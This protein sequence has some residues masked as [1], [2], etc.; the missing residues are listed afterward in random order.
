MKEEDLNK[1]KAHYTGKYP[2]KYKAYNLNTLEN[3]E[4]KIRLAIDGFFTFHESNNGFIV[5]C[6]QIVAYYNCGGIHALKR[7]F[8]C[9]KNEYEIH[10]LDLNTFNNNFNNLIYL[11]KVVHQEITV[12]QRRLC[13]YLKLFGNKRF[14]LNLNNVVIWNKQ[15]RLVENILEFIAY[16]LEQTLWKTAQNINIPLNLSMIGTW[17]RLVRKALKAAIPT[18]WQNASWL[19]VT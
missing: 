18:Y 11:P 17:R 16:W 12:N 19:I 10:H 15:G 1:Y 3:L 4:L 13:K 14:K 9:N 8:V 2:H 6:H 5:Y 7:G